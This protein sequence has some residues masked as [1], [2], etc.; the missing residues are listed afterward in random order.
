MSSQPLPRLTPE[1]YLATGRRA[2]YKSEYFGGQTFA[3]SGAIREHNLIASHFNRII[4]A[5]VVGRDCEVYFGDMRVLVSQSGLYTYPDASVVCGQPRFLD[6]H[7]D[8]LLNPTLLVEIL[9]PSTESYDR[10][11]KAEHYRTIP[12]LQQYV[13]IAQD[14]PH[15]EL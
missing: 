6:T 11:K 7:V 2:G 8:T 12:S 3:M 15:V 14:Y 5:Q 10:G 9:S 4:G 1:Q 13:L